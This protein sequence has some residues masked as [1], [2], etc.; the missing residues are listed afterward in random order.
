MRDSIVDY[1]SKMAPR[2]DLPVSKL[3]AMI[4]ITA[5]KYYQWRVRYGT[6]NRHNGKMPRLNWILDSEK[7]AIINYAKENIAQNGYCLRD[8]YRVLAYEMID[9]NICAVSPSSVWRV[10]SS[11]GLL[12]RYTNKPSKKGTGFVQP[13]AP[14]QEWHTDIK[15]V[16]FRGTFLFFI[17]VMDGYSRYI[18]H[19][20]LRT[21]MT[22][23]DVEIVIHRA[24]EKYPNVK[25][26]LISDN[27]GQFVS[28]EFKNFLKE[29]GLV[30]VRTSPSHPQANGKI[31]RFHRSLG[32]ECLMKN[33]LID[34]DDARLTV[35]NYVDKYNNH[36][37]HSALF[38]LRP[39]DFLEGNVDELLKI[40]QSKLDEATANRRKM[41]L[42]EKLVS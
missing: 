35:A 27:G 41:R 16:N 26:K 23:F 11:A 12:N 9:K 25:P 37:L 24:L 28:M 7:E 32:E 4:G 34:I 38:Y 5:D 33:S 13:T 17:S 30:N 3:T 1:C 14:H 39:V 40:R 19:H 42:S 10:L 29:V 21:S 8:G 2:A 36:R 6:P 22:E 20:E 15:Y 31:E 18:L